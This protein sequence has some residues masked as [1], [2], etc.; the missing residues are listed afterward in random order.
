MISRLISFK[1]VWIAASLVAVGVIAWLA[2]GL[3]GP[4]KGYEEVAADP[5][6]SAA[7][8]VEV[9]GAPERVTRAD[10]G[11]L[12]LRY[13][14]KAERDR[15]G[16][17]YAAAWRLYSPS[18]AKVAE[19][20]RH[21]ESDEDGDDQDTET[22]FGTF[23]GT[24]GGFVVDDERD[25]YFLDT[26]GKK[27]A[28]KRQRTPVASA[29]GDVLITTAT[30]DKG[31]YV[32]YTDMVYR[33]SDR[34]LAPIAGLP[35]GDTPLA[36]VDDRG[37]PWSS[38]GFGGIA[39]PEDK[40][41]WWADG[42]RHTYRLP[43]YRGEVGFAAGAG[44]AVVALTGAPEGGKDGAARTALHVTTDGGKHWR[45]VKSSARLPLKDFGEDVTPELDVFSDGRIFIGV[46]GR[47]WLAD[48][49]GNRS[50]HEVKHPV[51]FSSVTAQGDTLYGL[52]D[53]AGR[54]AEIRP[55]LTVDGEGLW[56]SKNGGRDWTRFAGATD[57]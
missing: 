53:V 28:V 1:S 6:P 4:E 33:P 37:T 47:S 32:N 7:D 13:L 45:V 25:V 10:D 48:S 36:A 49:A 50:F 42:R 54:D 14:A 12:L 41:V 27:H 24:E 57:D 43:E 26:R 8:V 30:F 35:K 44:T 3:T 40:V 21:A 2:Y 56:I 19:Y 38:P 51:R 23:Y 16:W 46:E 15:G 9:A 31:S 52:A 22:V 29:S 5:K 17:V 11:S 55:H 20:A 34:T 39:R 18:G